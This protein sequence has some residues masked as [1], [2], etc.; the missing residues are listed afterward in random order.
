MDGVAREALVYVPPQAMTDPTPIMFAFHGHGGTMQHAAGS[1]RYH[2]LW[3]DAIVV[4]MQSW[5]DPR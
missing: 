1:F 4:Y 2:T 5:D 3:P